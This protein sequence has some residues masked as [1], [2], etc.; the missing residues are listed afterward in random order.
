VPSKAP[1]FPEVGTPI[2]TTGPATA[3][4]QWSLSRS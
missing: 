4:R 3:P 2:G 1:L